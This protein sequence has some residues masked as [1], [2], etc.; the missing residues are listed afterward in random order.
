MT[1]SILSLQIQDNLRGYPYKWSRR[2]LYRST[3][4]L[5]DQPISFCTTRTWVAGGT[6][7]LKVV[8]PMA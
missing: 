8:N 5:T 3:L 1:P 7:Q 4:F 2:Y 6:F